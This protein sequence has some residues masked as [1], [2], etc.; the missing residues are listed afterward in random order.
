[1]NKISPILNSNNK[2]SSNTMVIK[3][4]LS[5]MR[6]FQILMVKE[7]EAGRTSTS[8]RK[9]SDSKNS[10]NNRLMMIIIKPGWQLGEIRKSAKFSETKMKT[11]SMIN[12]TR[13]KITTMTRKVLIMLVKE[14]LKVRV[15]HPKQHKLTIKALQRINWSSSRYKRKSVVMLPT[16]IENALCLPSVAT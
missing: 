14:T 13:V 6:S 4:K 16:Q 12:S 10:N 9:N 15:F 5:T 7:A 2:S 3:I 8:E 1:M 11:C